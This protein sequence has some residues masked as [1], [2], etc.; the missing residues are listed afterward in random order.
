MSTGSERI[1]DFLRGR[2]IAVAGVSRGA[3]SAAN[4]VFRKLRNAGYEVFPIN[5]NA[6]TVEG[7][8]CYPNLESIPG[9]IDG[10]V[11][12]THPDQAIDIVRQAIARRVPR[13]WFH[14]SFGQGSVSD[15]AVRA[16]ESHGIACIVGGCPLMYC[17]PVD[18]AHRCMRWWLDR[19]GR[20]H[21]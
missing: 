15:A 16:C 11:V 5:P 14:R 1:A 19:R 6:S 17:E 10:I 8:P 3:D 12:A 21:G 18:V 2:R 4:P 13:I 7:V 20:I 9:E